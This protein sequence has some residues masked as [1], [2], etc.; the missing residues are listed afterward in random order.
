M[1]EQN[2]FEKIHVDERD[3]ADLSGVLEQ[4]NLPPAVVEYVRRNQK[5]IYITLGIIAIV[6]VTWSLYGSYAENKISKSNSALAIA[7]KTDGE[8]KISA[9]Q[10]V[11]KDYSGT[12]A[13]L[14]AQ[15][16]IA[17]LYMSEQ[18]IKEALALYS[19]VRTSV[20]TDNPLYPLVVFGIAQAEEALENLDA[21]RQQYITLQSVKGYEGVGYTGS[22]RTYEVQEN[23][24]EAVKELE[25]YQGV[26]IGDTPNNPEKAYI[27]DKIARLKGLQ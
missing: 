23:Y 9:L 27:N 2:V 15:V 25:K 16:E 6:V 10:D 26:L 1:A 17:Q 19:D 13:S 14:W 22:S 24:S 7:L 4:L 3:K 18:K 5:A 20:S 11:T 8:G 21:A 12:D